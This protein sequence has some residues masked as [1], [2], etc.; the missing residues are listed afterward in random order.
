MV[1][2]IVN[3]MFK[4][5]LCFLHNRKTFIIRQSKIL[6]TIM[7]FNLLRNVLIMDLISL[8]F[9]LRFVFDNAVYRTQ[10]GD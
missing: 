6:D 3:I 8:I 10:S 5:K 9:F 7:K 1:K 4:I 2:R